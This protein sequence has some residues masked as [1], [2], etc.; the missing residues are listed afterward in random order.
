MQY[1]VVLCCMQVLYK[2]VKLVHKQKTFQEI[3]VT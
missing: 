2:F 1:K 3:I